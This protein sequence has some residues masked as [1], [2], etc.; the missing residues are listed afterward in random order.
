VGGSARGSTEALAVLDRHEVGV[1]VQPGDDATGEV[2]EIDAGAE[3]EEADHG[4]GGDGDGERSQHA[5]DL[6]PVAQAL[7]RQERGTGP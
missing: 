5:V 1:L 3:L 7:G 2:G 4:H 6:A